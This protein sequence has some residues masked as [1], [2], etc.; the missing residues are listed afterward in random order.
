MEIE[1]KTNVVDFIGECN[2]GNLIE[3]LSLALSDAAL[4]QINHGVGGKKAKISLEF[5]FQQMGDNNQVIVSHK[6]AI[7]KPTKRG[8]KFEEDITDSA[9]FVGKYG[10]LTIDAPKEEEGGQFNMT[11]ESVDRETG[12]IKKSNVRRI[13]N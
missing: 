6:L 2:A 3:K 1:R 12:E 7:T 5:T 4:A 8:K 13:A 10:R 9:F 11:Q